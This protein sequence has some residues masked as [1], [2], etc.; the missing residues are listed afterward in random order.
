[1]RVVCLLLKDAKDLQTLAESCLRFSP[2]IALGEH[3]LFMEI[4]AC[5]RLYSEENLHTELSALL[6]TLEI[7]AKVTTAN[8]MPTALAM[9]LYGK[10]KLESLPV[11][12]I[13]C[14]FNP[15]KIEDHFQKIIDIL[16]KLAVYD[17][18]AL[19]KIP[20]GLLS[21]K[22][23]KD[24]ALVLRQIQD[25]RGIYWP[26]FK[27]REIVEESYEFEETQEVSN[28]EPLMFVL[29]GLLDRVTLR[30]RGQGMLI[31][32][33]MVTLTQENYSTVNQAVRTQEIELAFPSGTTGGLL[34]IV[35]ERLAKQ[36]TTE[37]L[38]SHVKHLHIKVLDKVP[39]GFRQKDFF[40]QKEEEQEALQSVISRLQ[41]KLGEEKVFFARPLEN[42]FPEKSWQKTLRESPP[43]TV[44]LPE[45]PLRVLGTPA[46]LRRIQDYLVGRKQ[47]WKI[48]SMEGPERLS[49]D[50]WLYT[51][52][53]T[54]KN[55]TTERDYFRVHT[56]SGQQ[57]WVYTANEAQDYFLHGIYD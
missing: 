55:T 30:L 11:D 18:R 6:N 49:G 53:A 44:D 43:M 41:D 20:S 32:R 16:K 26:R 34:P 29:K 9:A 12:A 8:D 51:E 5:R 27:A 50:W 17:F 24:V 37:P 40:S 15:F 38:E 45:R 46:R 31:A 39:G 4:E 22:F 25:A 3:W 2:Q 19:M 56:D 1:V 14:Y 57:L 48:A 54:D 13:P 52:K 10:M 35:Q 47:K 21:A 23:N 7:Q 36:F 33:F 42:F 28:L